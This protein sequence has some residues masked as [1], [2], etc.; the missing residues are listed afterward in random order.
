MNIAI[1]GAGRF[2]EYIYSQVSTNDK[3]KVICIIDS[4]I[5]EDKKKYFKEIDIVS[6]LVYMEKYNAETDVVLVAFFGSIAILEELKNLKIKRYGFICR[7]V[8]TYKIP[9]NDIL[10]SNENIIWNDDEELK[11]ICLDTLETNV[12]DFCNLNCKGCS[13]FSNL[14]SKGSQTS[15]QR[16]EQDIKQLATKIFIL[17]FNLLG[18]EVFLSDKLFE[19]IACLKKYMPKTKIELISNGLII[20][21]LDK[22]LLEYI[23]MNDVTI[24]I[25]EYLPT[26]IIL[27]KIKNTLEMYKIRYTIRPLA[28]TFGKN[29]DLTGKN[30]PFI[31]MNNCR[32]S[33]CQFLRE[34]KIYKCP[35][36][37]LG[38]KFFEYYNIPIHFDEGINIYDETLDWNNEITKICNEPL[39]AC[40]YCGVEEKFSWERSDTPK[41]E[42][43]LI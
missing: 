5:R 2:G 29:I 20:P 32:E 14:Y 1:W 9:L 43:W 33:K 7:R 8:F 16:F 28:Q 6:P 19:Y 37:S 11:R 22:E 3:I 36:T 35:F 31:A 41:K 38:N 12:V 39:D 30:N 23:K 18:G 40:R 27:D 17:Q 42:E 26:S 21:Y 10:E 15:Y 13:H 34:G 4:N 25:T 24:D